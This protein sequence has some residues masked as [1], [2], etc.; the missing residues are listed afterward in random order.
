MS[1]ENVEIMRRLNAAFNAGDIET[2]VALFDS[3]AEL[4]DL[5]NAPDVPQSVRGMAA[6]REVFVA[7][8]DAFDDFA[9]DVSE[10]VDA[11][12]A[13]ICMTHYHGTGKGSGLT[14]D[15]YAAD[16]HELHDGLVVRSMLGYESKAQ[17]LEAVGL[18]E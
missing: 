6:I 3:E 12:R 17:A 15:F 10:Y 4:T 18:L 8:M 2:A 9:G 11:G 16:V 14:V 1:Q 5:L 13:V 7:W